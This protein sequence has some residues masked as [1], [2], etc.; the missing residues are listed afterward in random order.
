VFETWWYKTDQVLCLFPE[1]FSPPQPDWP[2]RVELVGFPLWDGGNKEPL[3]RDV[4]EFLDSGEP[5]IVFTPGSANRDA[6][7]FLS[8]AAAACE[9]IGRRGILLTKFAEQLPKS[10]PPSVRHFSFVP[11]SQLLPR[12]S[13]FVHHAGIGSCAQG[14]AAG[15][16]QLLRPMAFDQPDNADRLLRLGVAQVLPPRRFTVSAVSQALS[17]LTRDPTIAAQCEL[18]AGRCRNA[19]ALDRACD[20]L[21]RLAG[22]P[23]PAPLLAPLS[24]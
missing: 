3:A 11:F 21:E 16:P 9:R 15:V 1:W 14:L 10:L 2:A 5:P 19:N 17:Q 22:D 18:L 6:A 12:A 24:K 4:A 13:A 20:A 8:V 7:T 23:S